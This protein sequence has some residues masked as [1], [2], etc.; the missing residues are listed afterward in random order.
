MRILRERNLDE[1]CQRVR[2]YFEKFERGVGNNSSSNAKRAKK[3]KKRKA[4]KVLATGA[5]YKT[6]AFEEVSSYDK[7][8][9]R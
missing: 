7:L 3:K 8:V 1:E 4:T 2:R 5:K 9:W 6:Y